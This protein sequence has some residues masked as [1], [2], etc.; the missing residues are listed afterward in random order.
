MDTLIDEKLMCLS[1]KQIHKYIPKAQEGLSIIKYD[2]CEQ[3]EAWSFWSE[4]NESFLIYLKCWL[5]KKEAN[6]IR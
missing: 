5:Q 3:D 4:W 1:L 2:N 6:L